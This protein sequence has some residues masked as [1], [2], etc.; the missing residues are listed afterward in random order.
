MLVNPLDAID[1]YKAD[2]RRQYPDGTSLV[3]SGWTPRASRV[4]AVDEVVAFGLAYY[5]QG[6]L[7]DDWDRGFFGRPKREVVERYA[8]RLRNAGI[9]VPTDHVERLH[10]LGYL[11]I[12]VWAVPEGTAV[13]LGVPM[14]V[15]W[16]TVPE[17]YWLVN[18]LETSL[19]N[20]L[21]LPCTTATTAR[22]LRRMIDA[23]VAASGGDPGFNGWMGHDFSC[24]GHSSA[25]SAALSGAAHLTS[26]T[27]TDTVS[28]IDLLEEY[29]GADSDLE[30]VGGSVPATEHSVMCMGGK[31][32]EVETYRRLVTE[33]YP[34]GVASIVSDT[35]DYWRVWTEI[36]PLLK[37]EVMA[38][39]G[40]VVIRP[41]SGD[42]VR[43]VCGDPGAAEGSPA[44]LGSYRLAWDLFGGTV[45][46]AGFKELDPHVG[47][48]YGDGI[49]PERCQAIL[50]GLLRAGFVPRIVFGIGSWTYHGA[51]RD[52]FGFAVKATYGEVDGE[53]REIFKDP[54]TD[55][56]TKRSAKG[57]QAVVRGPD[58]RPALRDGVTWAEVTGPD[59]L[60]ELRFRDGETPNR[61]TLAEVRAR[62]AGAR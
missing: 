30:L 27:G 48:I 21:W 62:V 29:Y 4:E 35:W 23:A 12:E 14:L 7:R 57:L 16:N 25:E 9:P 34:S 26:F 5:L 33:V 53:P 1:F 51:T 39:D 42:P 10:D 31:E 37:D 6:H 49:T 58:G 15:M 11:P 61:P 59:S 22:R 41:D 46:A 45:N 13:P 32:A 40:C 8:R 56:G 52:T 18:Y 3:F 55:D 36:L 19:S 28:A 60:L 50:D 38:R 20:H 44:R 2:H 43:I 47:L 24:R 17:F 54:A